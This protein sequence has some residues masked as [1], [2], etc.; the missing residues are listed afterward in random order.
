MDAQMCAV[1]LSDAIL[2][3]REPDMQAAWTLDELDDSTDLHSV[4]QALAG[5]DDGDF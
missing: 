4:R 3:A 1:F 2:A 5:S